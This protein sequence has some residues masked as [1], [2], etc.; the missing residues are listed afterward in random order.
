MVTGKMEEGDKGNALSLTMYERIADPMASAKVFG[1]AIAGSG[2]FGEVKPKQ[3]IILALECMARRMPPLM[4]AETYHLIGNK[5]SMKSEKMLANFNEAGGRHR[6][7]ARSGDLVSIELTYEGQKNVFSLSW[8]EAK[9]EPFV[10]D[11]KE[12]TAAAILAGNDEKRKAALKIKKK[13]ATPRAR[14]QMMWARVI[15][16]GV[17]AVMPSARQGCYTPEEVSDY[18]EGEGGVVNESSGTV[19]AEVSQGEVIDGE[20]TVTDDSTGTVT[21]NSATSGDEPTL[22]D[23]AE[24]AEEVTTPLVEEF[25]TSAQSATIKELFATLG[26]NA[27]QI[28]NSL[29]KRGANN[30]RSLKF[31]AASELVGAL[32]GALERKHL[33]AFEASRIAAEQAE[34]ATLDATVE[35]ATGGSRQTPGNETTS[36]HGPATPE[37]VEEAKQVLKQLNQVDSAMFNRW[38]A[39]MDSHG[40]KIADLS[41]GECQTLL[42]GLKKKVLARFFDLSLQGWKAK[43][44][45]VAAGDAPFEGGTVLPAAGEDQ[46]EKN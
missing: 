34:Q 26:M 19:A 15:S 32:S 29:K 7:I 1:D 44:K 31:E 41:A 42:D 4:L 17:N 3:G 8:E 27:D 33:A 30:I 23:A 10:Y 24:A 28:A 12:G 45:P 36:Q 13:Y 11:E 21:D 9:Q 25:C 5:L 38:K 43:E 18:L 35:S 6:I 37:Q 16:D 14:M 22:A 20:F 40:M 39:H 46:S 2:M